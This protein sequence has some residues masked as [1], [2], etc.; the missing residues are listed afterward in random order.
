[1]KIVLM[2]N[3]DTLCIC[4]NCKKEFRILKE[5]LLDNYIQ[6]SYCGSLR[7]DTKEDSEERQLK[8]RIQNEHIR[9]KRR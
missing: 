4:R 8:L 7:W 5:N 2:P 3:I 1:M 6:C 9:K